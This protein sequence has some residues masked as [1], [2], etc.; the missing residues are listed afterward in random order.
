M[1][2]LSSLRYVSSSASGAPAL[3]VCKTI[4]IGLTWH[5]NMRMRLSCGKIDLRPTLNLVDEGSYGGAV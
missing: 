5:S 2:P 4:V 3:L 1:I